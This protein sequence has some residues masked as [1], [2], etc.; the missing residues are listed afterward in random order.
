MKGMVFREFLELVETK[1]G[2]DVADDIL[3]AAELASDGAYTAVGTYDHAE[4][5][6]LVS[7]LSEEVSLPAEALLHA[8]AD[9]LMGVFAREHPTFFTEA[10]DALSFIESVDRHIHVEV[11]KLYPDAELPRFS[12]ARSH[13]DEMEV[14]YRSSRP[15]AELAL[16]L[17]RAAGTHFGEPLN[18]ERSDASDGA[19]VF[20]VQRKAA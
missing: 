8:F 18:I 1:F 2:A 6:A 7:A 14:E 15:F 13:E 16:G 10:G 11:R 9:H 12:C 5:I 17:M 4:M 19:V 3:D 20:K